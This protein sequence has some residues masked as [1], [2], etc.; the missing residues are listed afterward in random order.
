[1]VVKKKTD[2][3]EKDTKISGGW[4]K[5]RNASKKSKRAK[6]KKNQKKERKIRNGAVENRSK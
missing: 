4:K 6:K 5:T 2:R 3:Q 1:V